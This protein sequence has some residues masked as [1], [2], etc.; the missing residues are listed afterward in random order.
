MNEVY[1]T[2]SEDARYVNIGVL[3][4]GELNIVQINFIDNIH[5]WGICI[6]DP[7]GICHTKLAA[8]SIDK[9]TMRFNMEDTEST[10]TACVI[11]RDKG[12]DVNLIET[13]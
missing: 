13:I 7:D 12:I 11:R 6:V 4:N 8:V 3:I 1:L 10:Y 5:N 9:I 2:V